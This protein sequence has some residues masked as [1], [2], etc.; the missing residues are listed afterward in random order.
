MELPSYHRDDDTWDTS[1]PR[2]AS[3]SKLSRL[4]RQR[5]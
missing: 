4:A 1:V 2:N 3:S 5:R